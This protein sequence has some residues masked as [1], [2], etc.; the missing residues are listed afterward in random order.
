LEF[1]KILHGNL[2]VMDEVSLRLS[3]LELTR[4]L[5]PRSIDRSIVGYTLPNASNA[6][7]EECKAL[8]IVI[9]FQMVWSMVR[10]C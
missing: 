2:A 1:G 8:Q 5:T 4:S 7:F 10:G 6:F 9:Y 3:P